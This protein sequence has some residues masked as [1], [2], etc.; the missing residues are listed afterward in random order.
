MDEDAWHEALREALRAE[1]AIEPG[2]PLPGRILKIKFGYNP[3]S[4][5]V[6]S[7]INMLFWTATASTV[8][9][10]LMSALLQAR[11]QRQQVTDGEAASEPEADQ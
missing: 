11:A 5:S 8:A 10:N 9:V 7:V 1:G 3:N 2:A 6:G 4:S